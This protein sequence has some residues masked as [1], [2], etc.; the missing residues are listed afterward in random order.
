LLLPP[1]C[2]KVAPAARVYLYKN[3]LRKPFSAL[4]LAPALLPMFVGF[5]WPS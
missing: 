5:G 3:V 2:D 1:T 4:A